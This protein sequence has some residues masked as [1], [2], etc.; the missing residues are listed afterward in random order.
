M[1][2][3]RVANIAELEDH[4]AI[5]AGDPFPPVPN[6]ETAE[7]SERPA[8][9]RSAAGRVRCELDRALDWESG[10]GGKSCAHALAPSIVAW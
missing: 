2:L 7:G 4:P 8:E 5:W 6:T 3:C 9:H 1:F 10:R